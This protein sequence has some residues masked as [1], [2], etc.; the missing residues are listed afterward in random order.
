MEAE[1]VQALAD[2]KLAYRRAF[3]QLQFAKSEHEYRNR[4]VEE[5]TQALLEAFQSF[6]PSGRA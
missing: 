6:K 1:C 4:L 3:E 2:A 5:S